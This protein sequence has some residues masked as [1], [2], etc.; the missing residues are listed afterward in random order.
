M[1]KVSELKGRAVIGLSRAQKLGVL[2][3]LIVDPNGAQVLGLRVSGADA[4]HPIV[5]P[6]AAIYSIGP[7]AITIDDAALAQSGAEVAALG[8]VPDSQALVDTKVVTDGG[9]LLGTIRDLHVDPTTL[10]IE[11]YELS[12]AG[13]EALMGKGKVLPAWPGYR[14][15]GDL[16]IVPEAVAAEMRQGGAAVTRPPTAENPAPSPSG[17][18]AAPAPRPV[19]VHDAP[20]A[21]VPH[22][23]SPAPLSQGFRVT[24]SATQTAGGSDTAGNPTGDSEISFRPSS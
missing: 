13:W 23:Q 2:Q 21:A 5:V 14:Y 12:G 15:G 7:D 17:G 20:T 19:S 9:T 4:S 3:G 24:S 1:M 18:P 11:A 22:L 8:G 10:Q 6:A 16:M